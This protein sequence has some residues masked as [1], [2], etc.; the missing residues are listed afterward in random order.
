MNIENIKIRLINEEDYNKGFLELIN[1]FSKPKLKTN[2]TI[3]EFRIQLKN[4]IYRNCFV[5]VIEYQNKIIGSA[6]LI[7][8]PKFHNNFYNAALI[9]EVII[10]KNFRCKGL[11]KKLIKY[12]IIEA[13]IYNCYKIVLN[14]EEQN[15]EFYKKLGFTNKGAEFKMYL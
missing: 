10:D 13:R 15:F 7:I 8:Q 9:E 3:N 5:Y 11:G 14:A 12:I 1:Y 6:T 2:K 4:M